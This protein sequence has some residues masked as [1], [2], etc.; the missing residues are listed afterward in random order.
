MERD[1]GIAKY[2][3]LWK[4]VAKY[5]TDD[6]YASYRDSLFEIFKDKRWIHNLKGMILFTKTNHR[7][8]FENDLENFLSASTSMEMEIEETEAEPTTNED[9]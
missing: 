7:T 9:L 1:L 4:I 8:D 2:R 5:N 3:E 6:D